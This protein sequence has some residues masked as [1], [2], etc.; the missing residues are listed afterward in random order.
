MTLA[1]H[2]W[3][4]MDAEARK[5]L[6]TRPAA[7]IGPRIANEVAAVVEGVRRDLTD[8]VGDH[9]TTQSVRYVACERFEPGEALV[10]ERSAARDGE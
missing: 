6:L 7:A 10:H 4:D 5:A 2:A 1:L 3:A 8:A 9:R